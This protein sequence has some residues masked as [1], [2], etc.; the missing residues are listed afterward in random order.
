M[1]D[2]AICRNLPL[3]EEVAL[4]RPLLD[5][6]GSDRESGDGMETSSSSKDKA[7]P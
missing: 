2:S 4:P 7:S 1:F 6:S 5:H 3:A